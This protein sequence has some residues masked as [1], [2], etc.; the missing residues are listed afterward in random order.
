M[1]AM[2]DIETLG[3][4]PTSL[5]LSIGVCW[6]DP[7]K[8]QSFDELLRKSIHMV[9]QQPEVYD[10]M[11]SNEFSFA[12]QNFTIDESTVDWWKRDQSEGILELSKTKFFIPLRKSLIDLRACMGGET[13]VW[14]NSPSFDL[15]ILKHAFEVCDE[16]ISWKFYQERDL[17][18]LLD[19]KKVDKREFKEENF[20]PHRADHDA[21][22]QAM[23]AQV[24]LNK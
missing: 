2:I 22:F 23:V 10:A 4:R 7:T 24:A 13:R 6:F 15:A 1:D 12:S 3:V 9:I 19:I 5:I 20:I 17:R 16:P 11:L 18:T 21:A 8:Q 14:A